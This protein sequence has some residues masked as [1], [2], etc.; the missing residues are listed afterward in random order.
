VLS[1][2][3]ES[4]H[5]RT[6]EREAA[7]EGVGGDGERERESQR[8]TGKEIKR[9]CCV[10]SGEGVGHSRAFWEHTLKSFLGS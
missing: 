4:A 6:R 10:G 1:Q 5:A 3:R 9:V 2:L 7:S 8:G